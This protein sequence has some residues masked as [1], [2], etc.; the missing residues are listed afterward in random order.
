M[1]CAFIN[2]DMDSVG[3]WAERRRLAY[4]GY[5][6]LARRPEVSRTHP[7]NAWERTNAELAR[8]GELLN[9]QI[10]RFLILHKELRS[11]TTTSSRRT[12]KRCARGFV[13]QKYSVLIDA[14]YAR[15][16]SRQSRRWS[17]FEDGRTTWWPRTAYRGSADAILRKRRQA[18]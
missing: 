3:N 8:R 2:I 9:S 15:G 7:R 11:R 6:D 14:L 4:S 10:H 1:V 16:E 18:A 13:A 12:R 17:R 5:A